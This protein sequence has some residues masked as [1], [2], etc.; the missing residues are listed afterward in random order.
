[1]LDFMCALQTKISQGRM[2]MTNYYNV[3]FYSKIPLYPEIK[4]IFK[5]KVLK[6]SG[7]FLFGKC[8]GY[9]EIRGK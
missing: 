9:R 1:M 6:F 2:Y 8:F 3:Y 7:K 4:V 5:L